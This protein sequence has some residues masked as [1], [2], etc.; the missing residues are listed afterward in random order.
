M[1]KKI[2]EE[3]INILDKVMINVDNTKETATETAQKVYEQTSQIQRIHDNLDE[4]D[5]ELDRAKKIMT[6]IM[7]R[8]LTDRILWFFLGLIF[9][10]V[11]IIVL[12][13]TGVLKKNTKKLQD[14]I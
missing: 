8:M 7:R 9:I 1:V 14:Q 6:K 11:I 13:E 12:I 2:Q 5:S 10:S 3:D 4:I